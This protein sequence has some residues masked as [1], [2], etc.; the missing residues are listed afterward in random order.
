MAYGVAQWRPSRKVANDDGVAHDLPSPVY[1]GHGR[2]WHK[3]NGY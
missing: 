3:H 1:Q 2:D